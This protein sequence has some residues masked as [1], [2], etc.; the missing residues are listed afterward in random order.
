MQSHL[1]CPKHS[2]DWRIGLFK[3]EIV[4]TTKSL[5]TQCSRVPHLPFVGGSKLPVD[6]Q[7]ETYCLCLTLRSPVGH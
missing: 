5:L 2:I 7:L 4:F 1:V 6:F 3:N